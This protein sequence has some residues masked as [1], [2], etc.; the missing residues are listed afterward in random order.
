MTDGERLIVYDE[1]ATTT[2]GTG[3]RGTFD[4]TATFEVPRPGSAP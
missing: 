2:S 4:F 3:N 1:S